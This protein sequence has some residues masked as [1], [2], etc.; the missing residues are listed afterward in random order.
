MRA[1]RARISWMVL[2]RTWPRVRTPVMFGGGMTMEKG[3]FADFAFASKSRLSIQR[4]YHFGSTLFGSYVFESSAIARESS[5]GTAR[6]QNEK[7]KHL[8]RVGRTATFPMPMRSRLRI[9][10]FFG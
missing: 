3:G 8:R 5:E 7:V 10:F 1:R 9:V 4:A 6:L 2:F